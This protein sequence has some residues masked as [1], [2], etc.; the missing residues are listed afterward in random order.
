MKE[1]NS[2]NS[3]G[4]NKPKLG[5]RIGDGARSLRDTIS[6]PR[7]IPK[8]AGGVFRRWVR[9]VWQVRGGG[10]YAAG[11]VVTFIFFE[12]RT[13]FGDIAESSGVGDFLRSQ[14]VELIFRFAFESMIN[15]VK[16]LMWPVYVIQWNPVVGGILLGLGFVVFDRVFRKP[17]EAWLADEP[18]TD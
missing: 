10:L 16:A 15:F 7:A 8:R 13:I 6:E 12:L 5:R 2:P 4:R 18:S 1:P 11:Y 14:F 17:V 9:K 3:T